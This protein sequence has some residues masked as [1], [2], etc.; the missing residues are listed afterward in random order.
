[1][2]EIIT[3]GVANSVSILSN[4]LTVLSISDLF[5]DMARNFS[6]R[7]HGLTKVSSDV[8]DYEPELLTVGSES[9]MMSDDED[10]NGGPTLR[11]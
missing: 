8:E 1:M 6:M 11:L 2:N 7:Y 10:N 5:E 9:S 3:S 4:L